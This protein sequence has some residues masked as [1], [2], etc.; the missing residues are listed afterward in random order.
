MF[1][2]KLYKVGKEIVTVRDQ[3]DLIH[4]I[5]SNQHRVALFPKVK[6]DQKLEYTNEIIECINSSEFNEIPANLSFTDK[7]QSKLLKISQDLMHY[8][9]NAFIKLCDMASVKVKKTKKDQLLENLSTILSNFTEST[10]TN[11]D[12]CVK[13]FDEIYNLTINKEIDISREDRLRFK[14]F[15]T[16]LGYDGNINQTLNNIRHNLK[17]LREIAFSRL[18]LKKNE[19]NEHSEQ[20]KVENH[21]KIRKYK[22][23]KRILEEKIQSSDKTRSKIIYILGG[24]C[25]VGLIGLVCWA[26][27]PLFAASVAVETASPLFVTSVAVQTARVAPITAAIGTIALI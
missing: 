16:Y 19:R 21:N 12:T 2:R 20:F 25:L 18:K 23:E 24:A 14:F 9:S 13:V 27:S 7:A 17:M 11:L 4:F 5:T 3:L 15:E 8:L 10:E 1:F 6:I 22:E 26:A